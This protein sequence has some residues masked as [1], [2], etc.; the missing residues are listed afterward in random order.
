MVVA[1]ALQCRNTTPGVH[2]IAC[3][4]LSSQCLCS[5]WARLFNDDDVVV[6]VLVYFGVF[7]LLSQFVCF[8]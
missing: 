4:I 1:Y 2:V 7:F 8:Y 6:I 5:A 3:G